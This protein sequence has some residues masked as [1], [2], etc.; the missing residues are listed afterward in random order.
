V[1]PLIYKF[2]L[3]ALKSN[4]QYKTYIGPSRGGHGKSSESNTGIKYWL[5]ALVFWGLLECGAAFNTLF[6]WTKPLR[7]RKNFLVNF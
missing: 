6:C 1:I 7:G 4:P 5:I 3:Y 2:Y